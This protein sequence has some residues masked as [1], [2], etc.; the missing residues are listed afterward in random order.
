MNHS[1][2]H[3][4]HNIPWSHTLTTR[5]SVSYLGHIQYDNHASSRCI[6][7][8]QIVMDACGFSIIHLKRLL[9]AQLRRNALCVFPLMQCADEDVAAMTRVLVGV[10]MLQCN[11][12]PKHMEFSVPSLS[13][14][15]TAL[16]PD[17]Q[18][19]CQHDTWASRTGFRS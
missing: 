3:F 19:R 5:S 12:E 7:Q 4:P 15:C 6:I 10:E 13:T 16:L 18:N 1:S 8:K 17:G 9:Y 11:R 14:V 2:S